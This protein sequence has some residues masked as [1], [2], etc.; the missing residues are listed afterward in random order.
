ML[1]TAYC[2][3]SLG[4]GSSTILDNENC[5]FNDIAVFY[6]PTYLYQTLLCMVVLHVF[7]I[8]QTL[9]RQIQRSCRIF[10]KWIQIN[11]LYKL[12]QTYCCI[13]TN[14]LGLNNLLN[15][16]SNRFLDIWHFNNIGKYDFKKIHLTFSTAFHIFLWLLNSIEL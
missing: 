4:E 11:G 16:W 7:Y 12:S 8:L 9:M 1:A 2:D 10:Q 15:F 6:C 5:H 14:S 3:I 13:D